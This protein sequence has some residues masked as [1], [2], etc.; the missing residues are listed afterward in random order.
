MQL[1]QTDY[2]SNTNNQL[3]VMVVGYE[4]VE[5]GSHLLRVCVEYDGWRT[6]ERKF[7]RKF[8]RFEVRSPL[9]LDYKLE[10]INCGSGSPH[11][12]LCQVRCMP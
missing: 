2:L 6:G 4:L 7:L 1:N 3:L 9:S 8:Y 5:A 12:L 11:T 10:E